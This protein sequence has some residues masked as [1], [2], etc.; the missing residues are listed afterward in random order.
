MPTVIAVVNESRQRFELARGGV[1]VVDIEEKALLLAKHIG[2]KTLVN[3]MVEPK[4]PKSTVIIGNKEKS[5]KQ[6]HG[7]TSCLE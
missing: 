4:K 2:I 1:S 3:Y 5:I 7:Y 6:E